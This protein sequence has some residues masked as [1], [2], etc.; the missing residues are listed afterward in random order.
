M[1][2][3][4]FGASRVK[5]VTRG[6][7]MR[8]I[9]LAI[10][11]LAAACQRAPAGVTFDGAQ[12]DDAM[13]LRAHGERLVHV[14]GCTGCHGTQLQGRLFTEDDPQYEIGRAHV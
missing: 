11:L 2:S 5:V 14:L 10:A 13:A 12:T 3:Y 1:V 7:Q 9:V 6:L 4:P 8:H